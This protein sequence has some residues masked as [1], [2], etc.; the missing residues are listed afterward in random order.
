MENNSGNNL[1]ISFLTLRTLL[2]IL[3]VSLPI[4]LII[5]DS[6]FAGSLQVQCSVSLYYYTKMR[7]VFVGVLWAFGLFLISYR[8]YKGNKGV[9]DRIK[10]NLITNIAGALAILVALLPTLVKLCG[11]ID[12]DLACYEHG[13]Q[14]VKT[15]H[16]IAA[17]LFFIIIGWM[18]YFRFYRTIG[19][20]FPER[21]VKRRKRLYRA[22]GLIIWLSIAFLA[23][24][25]IFKFEITEFDIF[26]GEAVALFAFG[27]AWLTKGRALD[28]L[29]R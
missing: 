21:L 19:E 13:I 26:I 15:I 1:V 25:F 8:G 14:L 6:I 7:N 29:L 3:G 23:M 22:C 4:I 18:S 27:I 10:D 9:E 17:G 11:N 20:G 5:G 2:G 12:P 24:E 16:L 28:K